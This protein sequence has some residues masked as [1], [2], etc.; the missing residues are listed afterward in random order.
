[1]LTCV[2]TPGDAHREILDQPDSLTNVS[3][4]QE[5]R[6]ADLCEAAILTAFSICT[7]FSGRALMKSKRL[8]S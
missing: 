1:M 5:E 2:V 3:L 8:M 6:E 4:G 7:G